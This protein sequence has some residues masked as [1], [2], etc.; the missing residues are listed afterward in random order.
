MTFARGDLGLCQ[1]DGS[2]SVTG[3]PTGIRAR[4]SMIL[5]VRVAHVVVIVVYL[6]S[7]VGGVI[8]NTCSFELSLSGMGCNNM[9]PSDNCDF[10]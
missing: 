5:D 10:Q 4:A 8:G 6:C 9:G 3:G 1:Y 2:G 7:G